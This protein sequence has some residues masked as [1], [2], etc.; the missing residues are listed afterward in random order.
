MKPPRSLVIAAIALSVVVIALT[1]EAQQTAKA[2]RI[3]FLSPHSPAIDHPRLEGLRKGLRD[4]GHVEG[5]TFVIEPRN[6]LG[7][8][9]RLPA[10][11]GE[12]V[13]LR[14]D[15]LVAHGDAA[16]PAKQATATLPIVAVAS[17]DPV[18][19]GLAES[20][21]RPGGNVS[22][23]SD[24][25]TALVAKRLA[26]LK[27]AVP[28]VSR[29]GVVFDSR[30]ASHP[31]QLKDIQRAAPALSL[32]VVPF[33]IR[34]PQDFE[35]V[36][37]AV[38]KERLDAV[39][40]LGGASGVHRRDFAGLAIRHKVPT[41]STTREFAEEGILMTYG[42]DFGDLYRRAASFVDRILKGARPAN[43]PIE[44][45]TKFELAVNQKTAKALGLTLPP[46]F[47]LRADH[48]I[49]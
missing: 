4:L 48:L 27:E 3:G 17:A 43:L 30:L 6:A 31:P 18:G 16:M 46:S 44:Q 8:F 5:T 41:M 2:W 13:R 11:A 15:V 33:D 19:M 39:T 25:H 28:S 29:I 35:R 47:L 38:R 37:A 32:A 34:G 10:L 7:R 9:D 24:L 45:A 22:G 21:A 42:S 1:G 36:F 14:V 40:I 23:L 49:Q 12:L 20:L 26:L